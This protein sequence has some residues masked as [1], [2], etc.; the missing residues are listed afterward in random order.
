M[1]IND[2]YYRAPYCSIELNTVYVFFCEGPTEA[3]LIKTIF[4]S[5]ILKNGINIQAV[6]IPNQKD[7][8]KNKY[9]TPQRIL[10]YYRE[11]RGLVND[12]KYDCSYPRPSKDDRKKDTCELVR[13]NDTKICL[14]IDTDVFFKTLNINYANLNENDRKILCENYNDLPNT[15]KK[16]ALESRVD[17]LEKYFSSPTEEQEY[18]FMEQEL[19]FED[20]FVLFFMDGDTYK[21]WFKARFGPQTAEKGYTDRS[22][23][24]GG[25]LDNEENGDTIKD[26]FHRITDVEKDIFTWL[27]RNVRDTRSWAYC[28]EKAQGRMEKNESC[29]DRHGNSV[30][31]R[32]PYRFGLVNFLAKHI[33]QEDKNG[34]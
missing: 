31:T 7:Q 19:N 6:Q 1:P 3:D 4:Q 25:T 17:L 33:K 30:L 29:K 10:D 12:W 22:S 11:M 5:H 16:Q 26:E 18:T 14:L 9:F 23:Y 28:I 8:D 20:F 21:D 15:E 13:K 32:W 34:K 27:R 2:Y 24:F